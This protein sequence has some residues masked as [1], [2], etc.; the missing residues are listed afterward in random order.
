[1]YREAP[2]HD[3]DSGW[4]FVAGVES[5]A[6]MGDADNHGI[7]DVNTIAKY[8]PDIIPFLDAPEGSAFERD[9]GDG[10]LVEVDDFEP[11]SD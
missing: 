6:H 2:D 10:E 7:Y 8:D 9:G 4:R 11:P 3:V 5:D 1:M